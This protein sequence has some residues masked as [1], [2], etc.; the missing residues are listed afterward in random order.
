[1]AAS[2]RARP[3]WVVALLACSARP[4]YP[5][6]V[7]IQPSGS[8]R[9]GDGS[10]EGTFS[11]YTVGSLEGCES[12]STD[13]SVCWLKDRCATA[14]DASN[15]ESSYAAQFQTIYSTQCAAATTTST[16]EHE[17]Q[18]WLDSSQSHLQPMTHSPGLRPGGS[19]SLSAIERPAHG[20]CAISVRSVLVVRTPLRQE[21]MLPERPDAPPV[22]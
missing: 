10:S 18:I 16:S 20:E 13:G 22:V 15:P 5:R 9:N 11:A 3:R 2:E 19:R 8:C 21:R 4:C 7:E 14:G 17:A 1:M 6:F 12:I